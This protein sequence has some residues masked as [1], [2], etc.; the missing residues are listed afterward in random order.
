MIDCGI[1][2]KFRDHRL[3][4]ANV[5]NGSEGEAYQVCLCDDSNYNMCW[6]VRNSDAW[7]FC[8]N[9][10][11]LLHGLSIYFAF[12]T[13]LRRKNILILNNSICL[14][15]KLLIQYQQKRSIPLS[16]IIIFNTLLSEQSKNRKIPFCET[17]GN[18]W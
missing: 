14:L 6:K 3:W 2:G 12:E 16:F 4:L 1:C 7:T 5:A 17:D 10:I 13:L 9:V 8:R 15:L 18:N 11:S